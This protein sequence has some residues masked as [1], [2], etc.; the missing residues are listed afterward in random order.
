MTGQELKQVRIALA[1]TQKEFAERLG[2]KENTLAIKEMGS[3]S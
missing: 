3:L 1:L 2:I